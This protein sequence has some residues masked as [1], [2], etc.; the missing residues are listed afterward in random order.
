VA[1]TVTG[2]VRLVDLHPSLDGDELLRRFVPPHRFADV[3]FSTFIPDPS[4]PSQSEALA[5]VEALA[6]PVVDGGRGFLGRRRFTAVDPPGLYLDGGFGVGKTHLIAALWYATEGPAAY[7]TF[8]ELT[9]LIGFVGMDAAV[10]EFADHRLLCLDE[11]ELDDVANTLMTVTF[12]RRVLAGGGLR[13]AT[14]SNSLPDRLGE[15]RFSAEDFQREIAAIA[16][17]FAVV[18]IDGPDVRATRT[19]LRETVDDAEVDR[20]VA[21]ADPAGLAEDDFAGLLAHLRTV[22]PVQ[23]GP[24]VESVGTVV[25][26]GLHPVANQGDALLLVALIDEL[27]DAG[28]T[29]IT[30]GCCVSE[31]FDESY[32]H[33]GY[34]KKYGRAESRLSAMLGEATA[35][36]EVTSEPHAS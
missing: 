17:H 20:V 10:A 23:Y 5:R 3:R 19:V 4:H 7:L 6:G 32:R 33:G 14:T 9:A 22:H 11:F 31:L 2:A 12:L 30:T 34:R 29:V 1:R 28:T 18:R 8:A 24:L 16:E 27:Y 15:G 13:V 25:V 26:R 35:P 36:A 21:S